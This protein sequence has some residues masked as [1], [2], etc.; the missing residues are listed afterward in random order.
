[1]KKIALIC[2][3]AFVV[4][5]IY[6]VSGYV[7]EIEI[8]AE[9]GWNLVYGLGDIDQLSGRWQGSDVRAIFLFVPRIQEYIRIWPNPETSKMSQLDKEKEF[10]QGVFWVY[11]DSRVDGAKY[12]VDSSLSLKG[13]VMY[14][15]WNFISL[16]SE[17]IQESSPN[18]I[19]GNCNIE[20][21][22]AWDAH[23]A[24]WD[25][26]TGRLKETS[27]S[28]DWT[29]NSKIPLNGDVNQIVNFLVKVSNDCTLGSSGSNINPPALP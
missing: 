4:L 27:S 17:N 18:D 20:R 9:K 29:A 15:G 10:Y 13:K 23:S 24:S 16:N 21:T 25:D 26:E 22:Y 3:L 2:F 12:G 19:R 28:A 5:G 14:E 11:S 8:T 7:G 1:M 6:F